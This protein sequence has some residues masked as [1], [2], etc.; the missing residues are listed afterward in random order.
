MGE[1]AEKYKEKKLK[2]MRKTI[3]EN[4]AY[5]SRENAAITQTRTTDVTELLKLREL[6]KTEYQQHGNKAPS[7][8]DLVIKATAM[9]L[10]EHLNLNSTFQENIIRTYEDINI[11]MAVA[12]PNGLITPVIFNA[13]KL[14]PEEISLLTI[15]AAEKARTNALTVDEIS[16]GTF[17]VTN[18]GMVKIETATPIINS[19]QIGILAVGAIVPRLERI[20]GEIVDR[21]KMFL[22]LTVDHRIIDGYPAALFLNTI[23]DVLERPESL[24][25]K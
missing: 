23:C 3:A 25:D 24:W 10:R 20:D 9:A 2:G 4:M 22:S 12:L 7:I 16:G 5:S 11:N 19:P 13:D 21:F 18:V 17:T 6:K 15:I 8:N 14:S 1:Q